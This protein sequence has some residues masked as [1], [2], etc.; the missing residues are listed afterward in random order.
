M[1]KKDD[2]AKPSASL[3]GLSCRQLRHLELELLE[4]HLIPYAKQ[5]PPAV[6]K[7]AFHECL[8]PDLVAALHQSLLINSFFWPWALFHWVSKKDLGVE[9]FSFSEPLALH[10][11]RTQGK[12]LSALEKQLIER[13]CQTH[14]SF[15]QIVKRMPNQSLRVKDLLL[16]T[17]HHIEESQSG[18]QLCD[19]TIVFGKLFI[20]E[21]LSLF[22][23]L[24]PEGI[25]QNQYYGELIRFRE[26]LIK[27]NTGQRL[28]M[29]SLRH[30]HAKAIMEEFI[31]IMIDTFYVTRL[32]LQTSRPMRNPN[33]YIM[34]MLLCRSYFTLTIPPE[35]ALGRLAVLALRDDDP[36][37]PFYDA[38]RDQQGQMSR[39]DFPWLEANHDTKG[40]C[41]VM[42]TI[43]LE[44][45]QL[46]LVTDSE[47]SAEKGQ[48]LL[49]D[50]LGDQLIFQTMVIHIRGSLSRHS[51]YKAKH[52]VSSKWGCFD[53]LG[54]KD[55]G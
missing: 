24:F 34:P 43:S 54:E 18:Y 20:L 27:K 36:E 50:L 8:P 41:K 52:P 48:A 39:V 35:K 16:D 12:A 14:Y 25:E 7:Q 6:M 31:S 21:G 37:R 13:H 1:D 33:L 5:L 30:E 9:G 4:E 49:K 19:N 44:G 46:L 32:Q 29:Q 10:Y 28:S 45:S 51:S 17:E 23:G 42:G 47:S 53:L 11:S 2:L 26:A 40:T 55:H 22:V 15:Y 38:T 3:M